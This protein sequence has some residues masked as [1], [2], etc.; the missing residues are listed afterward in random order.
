M[1]K[2]MKK[3]THLT[4]DHTGATD[5]GFTHASKHLVKLQSLGV[6]GCEITDQGLVE[7]SKFLGNLYELHLGSKSITDEGIQEAV[8]HLSGLTDLNL[9]KCLSITEASAES[10]LQSLP[11]LTFLITQDCPK[12]AEEARERLQ[13]IAKHAKH[14]V[15]FIC[16]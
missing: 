4:L 1:A 8:K 13:N 11:F 2:H 16:H 3:L 10:I 15:I 5:R 9:I 12:I 14:A 6:T 7:G